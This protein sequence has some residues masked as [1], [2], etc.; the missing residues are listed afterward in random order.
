MPENE[1]NRSAV[2]F[3]FKLR[4]DCDYIKM[5]SFHLKAKQS[6][7]KG[8]I[9][10]KMNPEDFIGTSFKIILKG[11]EE[12]MEFA[13]GS[14]NIDKEKGIFDTGCILT[15]RKTC[16]VIPINENIKFSPEEKVVVI[17]HCCP[18]GAEEIK[19]ETKTVSSECCDWDFR[20]KPEVKIKK[21]EIGP[22]KTETIEY[23]EV[24]DNSQKDCEPLQ[25]AITFPDDGKIVSIEPST[26]ELKSKERQTLKITLKMPEDSKE[27]DIVEFPLTIT[28]EGCTEK[29]FTI[30]ATCIDSWCEGKIIRMK[31]TKIDLTEGWLEGI[32]IEKKNDPDKDPKDPKKAIRI[33]FEKAETKW[34]AI[35][36]A[37]CV[38]ICAE[39]RK[40]KGKVL[41]W[42]LDFR[43]IECPE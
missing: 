13:E 35:Q 4:A 17:N 26:I 16:I 6:E 20:I 10:V 9:I 30:S 33:Y 39:E 37:M 23:Y 15:C 34:A 41:M 18:D 19:F 1:K 21:L 11:T 29:T 32:E 14:E 27:N 36:E 7:S 40:E 43:T 31:V 28:V 24:V 8:R 25:F 3:S 22:G 38:E 5:V 12:V 42:G 2:V